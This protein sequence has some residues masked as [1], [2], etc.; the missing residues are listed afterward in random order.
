MHEP[1][2][3]RYQGDD[4]YIAAGGI[5][6][7][8]RSGVLKET[9]SG[10]WCVVGLGLFRHGDK[11]RLMKDQDWDKVLNE[12]NPR[13]HSQE[14][15]FV[16]VRKQ[17]GSLDLYTDAL[18]LRTVFLTD[19]ENGTAFSTRLDWLSTI[20]PKSEIDFTVFGSHWL[21]FNQLSTESF[22]KNTRRIGPGGHVQ[23]KPA[24]TTIQQTPWAPQPITKSSSFEQQLAPFLRPGLPQ[25]VTLSLGLSGGLDSRFLLSLC[26]GNPFFQTHVFGSKDHADVRVALE[27]A[28]TQGCGSEHL[29]KPIPDADQCLSLLR[30]HMGQ[31]QAVSYASSVPGLSVYSD[32]YQRNKWVIDGG[33][34]EIARRQYL[35]RLTVR[36]WKNVRKINPFVFLKAL[37]FERAN[38]FCREVQREMEM[39]TINQIELLLQ[40]LPSH[41]ICTLEDQ[42]D[43]LSIRTRLPNFFGFEQNRIDAAVPNYM[44]FAQQSVLN[45]VLH[46]PIRF[47]QKGRLFRSV[48]RSRKPALA[49]FPLVKGNLTY[50]FRFG[51]FGAFVWTKIQAKLQFEQPDTTRRKFLATLG[52]YALD[53]VHS[54]SVGAFSP[55]DTSLLKEMVTGYYRGQRALA[56][57]VDWWLAFDMWRR[58]VNE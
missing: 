45:A 31:T 46:T 54:Q 11:C 25:N 53:T 48:I 18:G 2:I 57:Q 41:E 1:S 5:P 24:K 37:R 56:S 10:F 23:I 14:G 15:H 55:Y 17:R 4:Y 22:L 47:R 16:A 7:T 9:A 13:L 35:N 30:S 44:P 39:G 36:N 26:E 3:V 8:C 52:E 42:L 40:S 21:T 19:L 43:L 49:K 51:P 20:Q 58:T 34:G 27:I 29:H 38:I 32:L 12:R 33:F 50:P 6:E 28:E